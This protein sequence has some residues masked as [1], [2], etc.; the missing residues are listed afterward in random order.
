MKK[1]K[2]IIANWKMN[3]NWANNAEL[4]KKL[5]DFM[6]VKQSEMPHVSVIICPPHP[7][8][9]QA[10]GLLSQSHIA[11]GAQ[12]VSEHQNGAYTGDISSLM[13]GDL[14]VQYCIIGHSERRQFQNENN[15]Q[16]V[17]KLM[18]LIESNITPIICIGETLQTRQAG[19]T[20]VFIN[21]QLQCIIEALKNQSNI[22]GSHSH[23][24][25]I[26]YEPI[27]AI[28]TGLTPTL[29]QVQEVC[30]YVQKLLSSIQ[31]Q[32]FVLYGGSVKAANA[33]S[34]IELDSVDGFL[35][36][37]AS[38]IADEFKEIICSGA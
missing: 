19:N 7:Y 4:F 17:N 23:S 1:S 34:L 13:L 22:P 29:E 24:I 38:L 27:W 33:R 9:M 12:D 11:F 10:K 21:E 3:G 25:L 28:G 14:G 5:K 8:L 26:A 15:Q 36:G 6:H 20:L 31:S 30:N 37:G 16:I 35:V 18:R 32:Y 2:Y